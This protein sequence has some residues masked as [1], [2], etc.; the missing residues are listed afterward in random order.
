MTKRIEYE[1]Q[2]NLAVPSDIHGNFGIGN[3]RISNL[4]TVFRILDIG[5][6]F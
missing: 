4:D 2:C 5:I 6:F 3:D 1:L